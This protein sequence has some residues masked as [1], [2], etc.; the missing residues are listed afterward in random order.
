MVGNEYGGM[1]S[2]KYRRGD[3]LVAKTKRHRSR[4]VLFW[5]KYGRDQRRRRPKS[6]FRSRSLDRQSRVRRLKQEGGSRLSV[7]WGPF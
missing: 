5:K 1:F 6:L 3:L 7:G 2:Y 4:R